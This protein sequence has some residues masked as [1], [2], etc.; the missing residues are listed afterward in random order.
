[1]NAR[2]T[3]MLLALAVT[4][5]MFAQAPETKDAQVFGQKISYMEAGS[6]PAVIL[7]HGLGGD[8]TNWRFNL[9]ALAAKFHVYAIDELGFGAS[10]KPMIDYRVATES[11]VL[12]EF[13]RSQKI[14]K[15]SIVGSSLG[16]WI[17]ADFAVRYP[18]RVDRLVLGD[19]AG[20][21]LRPVQREEAAFLNP[22]TLD[23][24]RLAVKKIFKTP[25]LT[26]ETFARTFLGV[27][28]HAGDGYTIDRFF[29]SML[30]GEDQ[31]NHRLQSIHAKTLVI[32]GGDDALLPVSLAET[33]TKEIAGA[34]KVVIDG[35][36]HVP[37]FECA[38]RFNP[39]M[40]DFLTAP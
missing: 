24:A 15:A 34:K 1:M 30:R 38:D 14:E 23:D 12:D 19:A 3:A 37:Q 8:K 4:S 13:M 2:R 9:P 31:L 16:G 32:W 40:I 26:S 6:G 36:G 35:C 27:R 20:Y 17:A 39:A 21:F 29:D 25:Q 28:M 7:L 10:D 33:M 22:S 11:D 5:S 18:G